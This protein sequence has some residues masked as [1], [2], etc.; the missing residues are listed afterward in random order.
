MTADINAVDRAPQIPNDDL[1][2]R[3]AR[4]NKVWMFAFGIT[5]IALIAQNLT[6][7]LMPKQILAAENGVVV[8][9]I[10]FD[11]ARYRDEDIITADFKIW[12][13]RCTSVNKLTIY[14]DLAVCLRHMDEGL[15]EVKLQSYQDINY[16]PYVENYGCENTETKFF[17]DQTAFDRNTETNT[18][19]ISLSGE[20]LC[21]LPG[22]QPNP[23]EFS[24]RTIAKLVNKNS[25]NTLGFKVSNFEDIE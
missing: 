3:L 17:D 24:V 11:E 15:A 18:V 19:D 4:F 1:T 8:G 13:S 5:L 25:L 7:N 20:V 14:E 23:Q 9:Q 2:L 21:M 6:Y 10:Q 12:V 22:E 16:G